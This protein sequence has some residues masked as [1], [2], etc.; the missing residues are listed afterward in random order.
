MFRL[1]SFL[2][3]WGVAKP[4]EL[5]EL[6]ERPFTFSRTKATGLCLAM[7][8]ET[9]PQVWPVAPVLAAK[10]SWYFCLLL[11][12]MLTL[13]HSNPAMHRKGVGTSTSSP[14]MVSRALGWN[15]DGKDPLR[16]STA[17]LRGKAV[18]GRVSPTTKG[19]SQ[20]ALAKMLSVSEVVL[21]LD[22]CMGNGPVAHNGVLLAAK[23][24]VDV[25]GNAQGCAE[26]TLNIPERMDDHVCPRANGS[27]CEDRGQTGTQRSQMLHLKVADHG[28]DALAQGQVIQTCPGRSANW[29]VAGHCGGAK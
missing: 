29:D 3:A 9:H 2:M 12:A 13:S 11:L 23:Q 24:V 7:K 26:G 17:K 22:G 18:P 27:H 1:V 15:R 14:V 28:G 5:V 21:W 10:Q 6:T 25:E 8:L 4:M 19:P 20:V 16:K